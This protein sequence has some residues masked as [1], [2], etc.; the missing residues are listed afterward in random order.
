MRLG[1]T[2]L[3]AI[4]IC[5]PSLRASPAL[6]AEVLVFIPGYEAS[7]LFD[8]DLESLPH[9]PVCVWGNYNTFLASKRYFSLRL[10]NP[11]VAKPL[12]AAGPIDVYRR[13]VSTMTQ[14]RNEAPGFSPYTLDADF[15]IFAYDWRQEIATHTA[16]LLARALEQYAMVHARKTGIPAHATKFII[17]THSMGGL[18]ARTLLK[19]QPAWAARISRLY[20]VGTP[21]LGSVKAINTLVVGPDSIKGHSSGFPGVLLKALPSDVDQNVTKLVGITR[22]S[23]YELLPFGNPHWRVRRPDGR[24]ASVRAD[25]VLRAETWRPYWPSAELERTLFLNGW[26]RERKADGRKQ[27]VSAE[28]EFCQDSRLG[29]LKAILSRARAW[30]SKL[31]RLSQTRQLLTNV[32][33]SSRLRIVLSD[34]VATP[35]GIVT[36]GRHDDSRTFYNT[37]TN[38]GDGTV[39]CRRVLDDLD[40]ASPLVE[41]LHGVEHQKLMIDP[42]FLN[43]L[44]RELS[45]LAPAKTR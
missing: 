14:S 18:V 24:L 21:N 16:P 42:Q 1:L 10:P 39:E 40:G 20:L 2:I 30:R 4:L 7:Q 27:I 26:L 12:L 23:L 34:G 36:E 45:V 37:F 5:G 38:E 25:E 43:Y 13:F 41:R 19:Q 11:L 44:S 22:P 15:F 35:A 9:G 33:E 32:G 8:P 6:H 3:A 31:G 28:W 29:K 17:V